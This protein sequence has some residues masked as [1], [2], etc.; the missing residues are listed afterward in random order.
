M[1]QVEKAVLHAGNTT[2]GVDEIPTC[3]IK[4]AWPL[5]KDRVLTLYQGCLT[6]GYHPKCFRHATLAIIQKPNKSD[7]SSPRS[8][9]PIAL[10][11]ALGKGLE[12]LIARNVA[13]IAVEYKV[14]ANQQF[15][16]LPLRSA[17]DLTTCPLHD[18][19]QAL[20]Q[21]KTASLLTFDVKG[22]FDGVLPG[23]LIHRLR[24][25]GWPDKF[26]RWVASFATGRSVQIRLDG[27]EGPSTEFSAACHKAHQYRAFCS[28]SI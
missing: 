23:R 15:G 10:L 12:R 13:W 17:I 26:V 6:A 22:A 9:R 16:A 4:V 8:Y 24:S 27:E 28:C 21:G 20:N 7:W 18:V 14:L 2:P 5:I 3:I 25:Q 1:A 19:E 11:S